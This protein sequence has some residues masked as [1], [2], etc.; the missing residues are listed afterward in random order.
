MRSEGTQ[1]NPLAALIAEEPVIGDGLTDPSPVDFDLADFLNRFARAYGPGQPVAESGDHIIDANRD[2]ALPNLKDAAVLIA[3]QW[4][5]G[6]PQLILT[7][8][9]ANLSSHAGQI[10][11]PGGR[12]DPGDATP[13]HTALREACEEI[14]LEPAQ[15]QPIGQ[16]NPY[17]SGSGYR[18]TPVLALL[19]GAVELTANLDEVAD[20]FTVPLGFLMQP[21]SHKRLTFQWKGKLRQ[22]Y[23]M[24]FET[25]YIWGVTAGILRTLYLKLYETS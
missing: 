8:R 18:I 9:T 7:Q 4:V 19:R 11:F 22:A 24:P 6:L 20:I 10:A 23:A 15:V 25:H 17:M 1:A 5:A 12:M 21:A 2:P 13:I 14:G 16:M 3:V